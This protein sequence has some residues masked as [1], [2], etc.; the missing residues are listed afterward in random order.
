MTFTIP[1]NMQLYVRLLFDL[2]CVLLLVRG[3]Y[4]RTYQRAELLLTLIAFNMVIFLVTWLLN[5]TQISL[6]AAFG[7]FA[8]FSILRFRT[9]GLLVEDM[10]YLFLSI[11]LGLM[12]AAHQG[13]FAE[14]AFIAGALLLGTWLLESRWFARRERSHGVLYDNLPLVAAEDRGPLLAD[15][16]ARTGLT[17]HRVEVREIDLLKD[18]AELR[19]YSYEEPVRH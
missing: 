2:A 16:S 17:V 18:V 7:L 1:E 5:S 3:I 9:E 14:L 10:T 15:L 13:A 19:V 11:A 12:V 4:F 8:V 6:G